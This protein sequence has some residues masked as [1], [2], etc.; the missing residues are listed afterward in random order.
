[1][2]RVYYRKNRKGQKVY[3]L[4]YM[5]RGIRKRER[6]GY[7]KDEAD[8]A[9]QSRLVDIRREKFDHI[10]PEPCCTLKKIWPR[11]LKHSMATKS[12]RQVAREEGIYKLHLKPLF[13]SKNLHEITAEEVEN[14]QAERKAQ[15]RAAS[16]INKEVQLLKNIT[17]KAVEWGKVRTNLIAGVKPFKEPPGP[18]S[19]GCKVK[20]VSS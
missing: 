16:T 15:K 6:V 18:V 2:A 14:Y 9:L 12:R 19:G 3:Y 11:Y 20:S 10:L 13:D 4:D 1:M 17:K 8:E 5:A 7:S